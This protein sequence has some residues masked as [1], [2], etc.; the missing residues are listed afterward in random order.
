MKAATL[1]T[2]QVAQGRDSWILPLCCLFI[3]T[4]LIRLPVVGDPN[5]HPDEAF[6]L[7][8]GQAMQAG[9]IPY[10]DIWDRKPFG[11]FLIYR[12][13]V[14][15]PGNDVVAYQ[16]IAG[17]F[18]F[19]TAVVISCIASHIVRREA[20]I[21]AGILYLATLEPLAGGGGQAPVFYNLLMAGAALLVLRIHLRTARRADE[22]SGL[23]AMGLCGLALTVKPTTV[24][25]GVFLG[26]ALLVILWRKGA[27][28]TR[29][30][31]R[32]AMFA[33]AGLIP[34]LLCL[35]Y[36]VGLGQGDAYWFATI[37]SVF[38]KPAQTP[39][40]TIAHL[41]F[42]APRLL[43]LLFA[44]GAGS[45]LILQNRGPAIFL[46]AWFFSAMLGF[47]SVPNFFDHYAL[48]LMVPVAVLSAGIFARPRIGGAIF[49]LLVAWALFLSGWPNMSRTAR[50][51]NGFL[52][53]ETMIDH[54]LRGGCLFVFDGPPL[55]N[56]LN[57]DCRLTA[58]LFP[59]HLNNASE[60]T[61][62]G[63]DAATEIERILAQRP[64]VIVTGPD[65]IIATPNRQTRSLV[66][67]ALRQN[68]RR[69]GRTIV[70]DEARAREIEIWVR[71]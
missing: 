19:A 44:A 28:P 37:E 62:T 33:V 55:L 29:L 7:L 21:M 45:L 3:A 40:S 25:E 51:E 31:A 67:A 41:L 1:A 23:L 57:S 10:V 20:A 59:E 52:A 34:S 18:A 53:A 49:G 16:L 8:V 14:A 15:L 17:L 6:Y 56:R 48:P 43:P 24:F 64:R 47:L 26:I 22:R 71:R 65:P 36:F 39:Q 60:A 11:L 54:H 30:L 58:R 12:A 4:L 9:W 63:I 27:D 68:Y 69:A 66:A 2:T 50:S 32:G 13:I 61:A 70:E 38:G 46:I 42:L 35:I 5:Y